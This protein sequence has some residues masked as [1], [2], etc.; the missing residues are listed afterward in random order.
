MVPAVLLALTE[1]E[2]DVLVPDQ[3]EGSVHVYDVALGSAVTEYVFAV[4]AQ[5]EEFPEIEEG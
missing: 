3:P 4:P 5:I 2:L 1:I